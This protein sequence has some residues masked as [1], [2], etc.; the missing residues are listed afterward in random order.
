[1]SFAK[2]C[3]VCHATRDLKEFL[4]LPL[5][6][7]GIGRAHGLIWRLCSTEGCHSTLAIDLDDPPVTTE[8][9]RP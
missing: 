9:N 1:M 7:N 3:R 6:D 5:P 8:E 4:A 2:T